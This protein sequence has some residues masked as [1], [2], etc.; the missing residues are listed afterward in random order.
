MRKEYTKQKTDLESKSKLLTIAEITQTKL[1]TVIRELQNEV[2]TL[3]NK[4][5]FLEMERE[6]LQGQSDSQ[7]HLHNSQVQALEA[8]NSLNKI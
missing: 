8:V 4:V 2:K 5:E 1:E 7:T 6:N 3:Q